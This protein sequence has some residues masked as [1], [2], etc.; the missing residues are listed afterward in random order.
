MGARCSSKSIP[1]LR[2][3]SSN[4]AT[5]RSTVTLVIQAERMPVGPQPR[6]RTVPPEAI[7]RGRRGGEE[8]KTRGRYSDS[9]GRPIPLAG[10]AYGAEFPQPPGVG[11]QFK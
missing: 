10:G 2:A 1:R 7:R 4:S 11:S 9:Q 6:T 8:G 5:T 3:D